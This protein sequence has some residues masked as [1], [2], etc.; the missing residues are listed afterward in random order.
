MEYNLW[1]TGGELGRG[2]DMKKIGVNRE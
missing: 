1:L 2:E